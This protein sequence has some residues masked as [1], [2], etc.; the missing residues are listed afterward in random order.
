MKKKLSM[1]VF[2]VVVGL[3]G[4]LSTAYAAPSDTRYDCVA[5]GPEGASA[6]AGLTEEEAAAFKALYKDMPHFKVK[7]KKE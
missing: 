1:V 3:S 7:C 5:V 4:A 6:S 2:A